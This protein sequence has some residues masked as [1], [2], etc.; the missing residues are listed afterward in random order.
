MERDA[1]ADLRSSIVLAKDL[2]V[3]EAQI[4]LAK[5]VGGMI[6]TVILGVL[7]DLHQRGHVTTRIED[8]EIM[9]LI[10]E[11]LELASGQAGQ[12]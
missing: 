6:Q 10:A 1:L 7:S 2:K 5:L 11:H 8:R 3:A 4:D 9:Y 12:Q